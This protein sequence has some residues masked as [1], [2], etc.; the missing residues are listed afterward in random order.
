MNPGSKKQSSASPVVLTVALI[1]GASARIGASIARLLHQQ[2]Y[3]ILIHYN[4]SRTNAQDLAKEL[5]TARNNSAHCIQA[6]LLDNQ[7]I[8]KLA[9]E[10]IRHWGKLDVLINN[11]SS[12]FE[13]ALV[14]ANEQHWEDLMGTNARAPFFLL[15]QVSQALSQSH[16]CVINIT[17]IYASR[18]LKN[19]SIYSMAKAALN[20]M[21]RVMAKELA[22]DVRVN[23][24]APGA[25]L[26]PREEGKKISDNEKQKIVEQSCLRRTGTPDDI[27]NTVLF[28]IEQAS[29]VTGQ[30]ITVDGGRSLA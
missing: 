30:I 14:Q 5:N 21:T 27:A 4:R 13:T 26:W 19:Y 12:F 2:G 6:D 25:I 1:T 24:V 11:A 22:P 3:N 23:A 9:C 17:D 29:Y 18:G 16:G 7:Q 28:L 15:Q 8:S 10:S 20:N